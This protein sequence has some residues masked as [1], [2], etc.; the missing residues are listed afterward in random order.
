MQFYRS[1]FHEYGF[2]SLNTESV[3]SR[4]A[5]KQYGVVF[6]DFF[7]NIPY[8]RFH[9]FNG[10]F[11]ALNVVT[12]FFIHKFTEYER[13]KKFESHFFRQTALIKFKFRSYDDNRTSGV[14][15]TL[16]E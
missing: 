15:D 2:E 3:K 12:D 7:E 8:H 13:L 1:S 9:S 10:A 16:T 5:V 6:Y 4:S 11:C 14:V